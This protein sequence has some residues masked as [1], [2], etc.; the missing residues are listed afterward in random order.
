MR[1]RTRKHLLEKDQFQ[2]FSYFYGLQ[3]IQ[4]LYT[5]KL[6]VIYIF[7]PSQYK[8][9][10]WGTSGLTTSISSNVSVYLSQLRMISDFVGYQRGTE[11]KHVDS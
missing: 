4:F 7:K 8:R 2:F 3:T 11:L 1:Q 9:S 10:K 6:G 5:N